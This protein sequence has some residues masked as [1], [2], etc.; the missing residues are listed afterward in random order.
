MI[1]GD[2]SNLIPVRLPVEWEYVGDVGLHPEIDGITGR[3]V[4]LIIEKR[5]TKFERFLSKLLR[6][7]KTVRRTMHHTQSMLWELIDGD[8]CVSDICSIMDSLYH[9]DIAPVQDRIKA[10]LEIFIR[11]N[12]VSMFKPKEEE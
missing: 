10:Y 11:L 1:E 8:R 5:F 2:W 7:P 6:A 3:N 9:E 12:V 4:V